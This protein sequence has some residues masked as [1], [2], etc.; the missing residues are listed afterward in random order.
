MDNKMK[1]SKN[2]R[3]LNNLLENGKKEKIKTTKYKYK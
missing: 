3:K 2:S 1:K